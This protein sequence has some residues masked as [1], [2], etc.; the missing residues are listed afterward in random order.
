MGYTHRMDKMVLLRHLVEARAHVAI[1]EKHI[2][3]QRQIVAE[4][5]RAEDGDL[6]T[7]RALLDSYL[8]LQV[9]HVADMKRLEGQ[10]A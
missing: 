9:Q 6:V 8:Q 3:R 5:E 7:A 2:A 1:G 10:L 4:L